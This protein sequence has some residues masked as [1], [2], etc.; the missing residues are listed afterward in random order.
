[1]GRCGGLSPRG[2]GNLVARQ[3]LTYRWHITV[4]PRVGGGTGFGESAPKSRALNGLS[5][6]G[7]GNRLREHSHYWIASPKVYPRVGGGT[8]HRRR[9]CGPGG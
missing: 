5:P 4:Y 2:R 6:R 1:M 9:I 8:S 3:C 7:R